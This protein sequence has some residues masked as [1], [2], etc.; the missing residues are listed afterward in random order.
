MCGKTRS[1]GVGR[2][3][4]VAVDW[5][6]GTCHRSGQC[7]QGQGFK[8]TSIYPRRDG[9]TVFPFHRIR[10]FAAIR[11]SPFAQL[12]RRRLAGFDCIKTD[13]ISYAAAERIVAISQRGSIGDDHVEI[14]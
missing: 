8:I 14:L 13:S 4:E 5:T 6:A 2:S 11:S 10:L 12:F 1:G 9:T 3:F 7:F